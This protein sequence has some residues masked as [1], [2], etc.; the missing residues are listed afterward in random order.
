M[1][2]DS[3]QRILEYLFQVHQEHRQRFQNRLFANSHHARFMACRR[4]REREILLEEKW[5]YRCQR[6]NLRLG[7]RCVQRGNG[8][9]I[10]VVKYYS[11]LRN[12]RDENCVKSRDVSKQAI[13]SGLLT[14][15]SALKLLNETQVYNV[16]I[17]STGNI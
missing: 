16:L 8:M 10:H 2:L 11:L 1:R 3:R 5:R 17:H 6:V 14:Q 13:L 9:F 15:L 12:S 4:L 7:L